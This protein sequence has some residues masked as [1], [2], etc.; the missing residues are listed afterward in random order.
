M[1]IEQFCKTMLLKGKTAQETLDLVKQV[2]PQ[3]STSIKCIYYYSSKYKIKLKKSQEI[4][5]DALEAALA[6]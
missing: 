2:Y 4:N 3:S 5:Q 1:T 6:A